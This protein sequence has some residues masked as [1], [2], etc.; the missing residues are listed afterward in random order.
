M[1]SMKRACYLLILTFVLAGTSSA[2]WQSTADLPYARW[3]TACCAHNGYVYTIGGEQTGIAH[4]NV[5]YSE[6]LGD[7]SLTHPWLSTTNLP[8]A[9]MYHG[10]FIYNNYLFVLGGWGSGNYRDDVWS[11]EIHADGSIGSWTS[12]T[13]L[14]S[15]RTGYSMAVCN[16]YVYVFNGSGVI[17]AQINDDG[18]VGEWESTTNIPASRDGSRCFSYN[19]YLYISG[20]HSSSLTYYNNVWFAQSE[21][22]GTIDSWTST[23]SLPAVSA[24]HGCCVEDGS[25][26][27]TGGQCLTSYYSTA[28]TAG[29]QTSG[30]LDSWVS[31]PNIPEVR[32]GHGYCSYDGYLYIIGGTNWSGNL[33]SVRYAHILSVGISS[34]EYQVSSG[35]QVP[36]ISP[37]PFHSSTQINYSLSEPAHVSIRIYDCSGR[38]ISS[39]ADGDLGNGEHSVFWHCRDDNGNVVPPGVYYYSL[40][41]DSSVFT[42]RMVNLE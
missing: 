2:Q 18:T 12:T 10:C 33:K 40:S 13:D 27:I 28:S 25:V 3:C 39:L 30:P 24:Y 23:T 11:A 29:I 35:T 42:G 5:W 41:I 34:G 19:N 14:P 20:G 36:Q 26:Y 37:N 1:Y 17:F 9:R 7:G 21:L 15:P 16:G 4:N 8:G 38:M 6:I 32:S 22:N 31:F